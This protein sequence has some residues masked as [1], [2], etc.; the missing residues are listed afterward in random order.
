MNS[1]G[2]PG[3][4]PAASIVEV[5]SCSV[6]F[7]DLVGYSR[8]PDDEQAL[9]KGLLNDRV[10]RA[11]EGILPDRRLALDTGDGVALGFSEGPAAALAAAIRLVRLLQ[12][13]AAELPVRMGLHAGPVRQV[14]DINQRP[15]LIGDAMN[16]GHRIMDFAPPGQLLASEDFLVLH[17]RMAGARSTLFHSLGPSAD[18]HG[19]VH[20]LHRLELAASDRPGPRAAVSRPR[21]LTHAQVMAIEALLE[22]HVGPAA[23]SHLRR[24]IELGLDSAA[25]VEALSHALPAGRIR[26]RFLAEALRSVHP[27]LPNQALVASAH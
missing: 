17:A 24:Q 8:Q 22:R 2:R 5:R 27:A 7:V 26:Q 4:V 21:P 18:K 16:V 13:H 25:L 19:R 1:G 9:M 15:N 11:L 10:N 20:E 6:L 23:R 14:L 12:P 3:A